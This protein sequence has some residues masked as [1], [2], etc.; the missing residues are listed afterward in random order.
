[1]KTSIY[2]YV[3][4]FFLISCNTTNSNQEQPENIDNKLNKNDKM[5]VEINKPEVDQLVT[6]IENLLDQLESKSIIATVS[7]GFGDADVYTDSNGQIRL[8][9]YT[10]GGPIEYYYFNEDGFLILFQTKE[11]KYQPYRIII[12]KFYIENGSVPTAFHCEKSDENEVCN[13]EPIQNEELISEMEMK[14]PGRLNDFSKAIE[15]WPA[16]EENLIKWSK[17]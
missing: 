12:D 2:A 1:M 15:N 9:K 16:I 6:N 13:D 8:I 5:K 14:I 3:I 4:F 17:K 10:D 7:D 11:F